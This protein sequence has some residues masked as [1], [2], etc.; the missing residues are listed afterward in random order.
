[1]AKGGANCCLQLPMGSY[2]ELYSSQSVWQKAC[3]D[4]TRSNGFKLREGRFRL[5]IRKKSFYIEGGETLAQV[6]QRSGGSPVP[7]NIQGQIGWGSE[8]PGLV[9]DVPAHCRGLD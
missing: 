7:G 4:R 6:A 1:M 2:R 8:Q 9:E 5:D 3:C